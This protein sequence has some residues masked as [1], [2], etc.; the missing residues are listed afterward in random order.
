MDGKPTLTLVQW[1]N[2]ES[3]IEVKNVLWFTDI[4]WELQTQALI[5]QVNRLN[6]QVFMRDTDK[7]LRWAINLGNSINL[8]EFMCNAKTFIPIFDSKLYWTSSIYLVNR[9]F[10]EEI[11]KDT[12]IFH[13]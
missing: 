10:I 3:V 5:K 13:K 9:R 6:V 8:E 2:E 1:E 4:K 11:K 7:V 12:S